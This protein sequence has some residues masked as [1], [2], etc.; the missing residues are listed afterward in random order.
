MTKPVRL[1]S[2]LAAACLA[3]GAVPGRLVSQD[4]PSLDTAAAVG[5]LRD[6][7][8]VCRRDGGALWGAPLC[9]PTL[10]VEPRTR[11]VVASAP[12]SGG[13][14]LRLV[15]DTGAYAGTLP[16]DVALANTSVRWGGQDWAMVLLPLPA[17]R[18][19]R[20]KL[21]AHESFHRLQPSLGLGGRD[22]V[23]AQL[24]ERDGR[25][26]FRL[27]LRALERA[28]RAP[29]DSSRALARDA[30]LFRARR[31][32]LYPGSD[33]LEA[34]LERQEG[35]AEYT[36]ARVALLDAGEP[37][38]RVAAD[39]ARAEASPRPYVRSFAY[40]TGPAL[41]LLL[42][43]HDAGWRAAARSTPS[44]AARL[45]AAVG[46]R[47]PAGTAL[48]ARARERA[49]RYAG[50][51]VFA[52]EAARDRERRARVAEYRARLVDGPLLLLRQQGLGLSFDPGALFPLGA[53]GTVYPTGTFSGPWGKLEVTSGGALLAGDFSRLAVPAPRDAAARP[54]AG[55]GWR[56]ELAPGWEVRPIASRARSVEVVRG[57]SR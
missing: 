45:A 39:L 18:Y 30:L 42:D 16:R 2:I 55:D 7:A 8:D 36:G 51:S 43:R 22:P 54:L 10:L 44:L 5:A 21:L 46:F 56:L 53:L 40:A 14:L 23:N 3:P 50:D 11:T 13:A 57:R 4:A 37:E 52:A 24:D 48:E 41:G 35:L 9:G 49:R 17:D 19:E 27:E 15:S 28:L 26:W 12:D 1:L 32:R 6:L 31:N 33:T 25:A 20:V 38:S 47:A 29:A 34:A